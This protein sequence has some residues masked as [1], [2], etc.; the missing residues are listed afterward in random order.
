MRCY[1]TGSVALLFL[2]GGGSGCGIIMPNIQI[3]YQLE[4]LTGVGFKGRRVAR[5][6]ARGQVH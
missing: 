3:N 6:R 5:G 1:T 2:V 4:Q